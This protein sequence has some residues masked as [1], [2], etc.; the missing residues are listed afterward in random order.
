MV[1]YSHS[2]VAMGSG[3]WTLIQLNMWKYFNDFN[4]QKI[5]GKKTKNETEFCDATVALGILAD[6][7]MC[8]ELRLAANAANIYVPCPLLVWF[9][10]P[11]QNTLY[12][13]I[14]T[15][16]VWRASVSSC[17]E[18]LESRWRTV[19]GGSNK[20]IKFVVVGFFLLL[21]AHRTINNF[22]FSL[23]K[24]IYLFRYFGF[25]FDLF[26]P[27]WFGFSF[28]QYSLKANTLTTGLVG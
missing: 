2:Q 17:I 21:R 4:R 24:W 5:S 14:E 15:K 6:Y 19:D 7:E 28:S 12:I 23:Q 25:F 1:L 11:H 16:S 22:F 3:W 27:S 8:I 26:A 13:F 18:M 9:S 10:L 20:S